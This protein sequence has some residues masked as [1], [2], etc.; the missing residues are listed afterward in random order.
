MIVVAA[1]LALRVAYALWKGD[2]A[3]IGD[4]AFYRFQSQALPAGHGFLAPGA[5]YFGHTVILSA[6]HPP[7]YT[8][9]LTVAQLLGITDAA[10]LRLWSALLGVPTILATIAAGLIALWLAAD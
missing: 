1:G 8:L 7:L 9:Y 3:V 10:G 4:A 6:E 5:F 2:Q